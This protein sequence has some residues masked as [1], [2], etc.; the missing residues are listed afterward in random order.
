MT[1]PGSGFPNRSARGAGAIVVGGDYQGLGIVR[2]IGRL[3]AP[4]YVLDDERSISRF[5]RYATRSISVPNLTDEQAIV[6]ALLDAARTH[7]LEGWVVFPTRDECV[8]AISRR[9]DE[10]S[11]HLRIPTADWSAVRWTADKRD[12]FSLAVELDIPTPLTVWPRSEDELLE[13]APQ[14]PA[15]IK[16]AV[17]TPFIRATGDKA[18][19]ADNS[20]DLLRLYRRSR[21][22]V[23][24]GETMVQELI[25]GGGDRQYAYCAF[26]K[27]GEAVIAMHARRRRQ[28]PWEFGRASTYVETVDE[29]PL[30]AHSLKLLRRI[31]YDGLVELEFKHD[32]RDDQFKLLD[33]NARTWGY[34]TLGEAAGVDFA[35]ALYRDQLAEVVEPSRARAGVSW[36]RLLTDLPTGVLDVAARRTTLGAYV[37]SLFGA[38]TEAVWDRRDPRPW[39]AELALLPY[40]IVKRGF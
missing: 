24:D 5:S 29:E 34:H 6:D 13:L 7:G 40:L 19:R 38:D 8:A 14:L 21:S 23:G 1:L 9:R 2:S 31:G 20:D 10:L 16:P 28:H 3:G 33:I 27:D 4:V 11:A 36:L 15:V 26:F 22:I 30:E 32:H 17:K 12:T 39:F 25:P 18:W 37:R 35:G